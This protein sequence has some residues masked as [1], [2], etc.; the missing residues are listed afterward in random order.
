MLQGVRTLCGDAGLARRVTDFQAAHPV[1]AGQRSVDQAVER[2]WI[3]V[4]FVERER[5]RLG[6]VLRDVADPTAR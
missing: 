1:R 2:L 3:N 6:A 5:G 4:G